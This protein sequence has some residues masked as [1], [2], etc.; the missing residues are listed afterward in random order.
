MIGAPQAN[1]EQI[2]TWQQAMADLVADGKMFEFSTGTMTDEDYEVGKQ[3]F[4]KSLEVFSPLATQRIAIVRLYGQ[5]NVLKTGGSFHS[6]FLADFEVIPDLA[7][8]ENP[9]A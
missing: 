3:L 1:L 4:F 2:A 5:A 8:N 7:V 9:G 6:V